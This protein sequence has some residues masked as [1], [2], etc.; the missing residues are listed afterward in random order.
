MIRI[1]LL[2]A[3]LL[4]ATAC[5]CDSGAKNL[6]PTPEVAI[7]IAK[8]VWLPIYGAEYVERY[9]PLTAVLQDGQW[10]VFG[11]LPKGIRGGGSP[12]AT[13]SKE[14][15]RITNVHLAR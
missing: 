4:P 3:L 2:L 8:A 5:F 9:E 15:G 6:V 13:I 11:S 12:E 10:H 7:R 1:S 14:D